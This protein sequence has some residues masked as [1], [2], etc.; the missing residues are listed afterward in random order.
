MLHIVK[1]SY[2]LEFGFKSQSFNNDNKHRE[3]LRYFNQI[4][5]QRKLLVQ[6]K[7]KSSSFTAYI[8]FKLG[9]I[10][11]VHFNVIT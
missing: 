9:Y 8:A 11:A 6:E 5:I 2:K 4:N 3:L 7:V 10:Q 1:S